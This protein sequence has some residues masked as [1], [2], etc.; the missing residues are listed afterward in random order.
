MFA[1]KRKRKIGLISSKN[2]NYNNNNNIVAYLN[3]NNNECDPRVQYCLKHKNCNGTSA[4]VRVCH[5]FN[6]LF[7]FLTFFQFANFEIIISIL[8]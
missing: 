6:Q 7:F 5:I 2:F 3:E 8:I 4:E 1:N